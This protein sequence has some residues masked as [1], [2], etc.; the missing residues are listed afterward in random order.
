MKIV[1]AGGGT[2]GHVEPA[3]A[4][5]RA[6]RGI[7][8]DSEIVFLGTRG[9]LE[10]KLIPAAGYK[11]SLITRVRIP[12]KISITLFKAPISF[13]A[14]FSQCRQ[15][16]KGSDLLVGFGGYV[17]GPAYIAAR[18]LQVP[19][20][21]HE[22]NAK[23]GIANKFGSLFTN[24]LAVAQP[25]ESGAFSEALI[26]GL[27]LRS[28][29]ASALISSSQNWKEARKSAKKKIGFDDALPVVLVVGG[30]QG[31]VS[32]NKTISDSLDLFASKKIQVLHGVGDRNALTES[33]SLYKPTAY[34][35]DMASAY[36]AA[37]L[38]IS[39]SGAV[40][41]SEVAALGRY[42]LFIPLPIGNGEQEINARALVESGRAEII[43]Q[44]SFSSSWLSANIDRLL[45]KSQGQSGV[46]SDSDLDAAMKITALM[47]N[48]IGGADL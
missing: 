10:E 48:A 36:L 16:I 9:G 8:P 4:T 46:G 41:C 22:A 40:T 6:W 24:N 32:L 17:S 44:K 21:I 18:S 39:R 33:T 26:T 42:A 20:V 25:V 34:I 29:V 7:H 14:A 5:A 23:P 35:S 1:L 15:V 28:D 27:P 31:S 37:D 2:A 30:S 13:I 3:L 45:A 11:L 47:Q 38:V 12:R 19:I 43:S